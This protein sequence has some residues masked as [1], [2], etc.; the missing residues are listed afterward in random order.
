M[1]TYSHL[2]ITALAGNRLENRGVSISKR[3][4]L[5]GAVLPDLALIVLSVGFVVYY[6]FLAPQDYTNNQVFTPF[7]HLLDLAIIGYLAWGWLR[8]RCPQKTNL[9][10]S[11]P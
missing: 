4:F 3:T 7:E 1:Q 9:S 5:L 2:L 11:Q 8:R 10:S 6:R